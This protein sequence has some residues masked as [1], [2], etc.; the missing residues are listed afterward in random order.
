MEQSGLE[1]LGWVDCEVIYIYP[2]VSLSFG[3]SDRLRTQTLKEE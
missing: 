1:I 2:L 3:D